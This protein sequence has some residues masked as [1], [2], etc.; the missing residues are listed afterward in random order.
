MT[1]CFWKLG[2]CGGLPVISVLRRWKWDSLEQEL[3]VQQEILYQ[4]SVWMRVAHGFECLLI[5]EGHSLKGLEGVALEWVWPRGGSVSLGVGFGVS[6]AQVRSSVSLFLLSGSMSACMPPCFPPRCWRVQAK[7]PWP[8]T[9]V[10][11]SDSILLA[12]WKK[13]QVPKP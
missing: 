3:R 12:R 9:A 13:V 5:R 8:N 4:C 2:G 10:L 1:V 11:S 7:A 6:E